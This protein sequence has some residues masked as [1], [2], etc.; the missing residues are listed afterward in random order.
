M[1]EQSV[2]FMMQ[3]GN[4][5]IFLACDQSTR[6]KLRRRGWQRVTR[7]AAARTLGSNGLLDGAIARC[8]SGAVERRSELGTVS[9]VCLD[10]SAAA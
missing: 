9:V 8:R 5:E 7:P 6:D 3:P 2:T 10:D 4:S 1:S